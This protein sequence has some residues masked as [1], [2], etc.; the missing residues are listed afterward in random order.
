M[1]RR[2]GTTQNSSRRAVEQRSLRGETLEARRVMATVTGDFN[3]DGID[4][5]AHGLPGEDVGA[6]TDAGAVNVIYG[7]ASYAGLDTP[8]NQIWHQN[9]LGI[10]DVAE[11]H[12]RFGE[13]LAAG[14]FN[15]DGY[16]DLAIAVPGEDIGTNNGAGAVNVIYGSEF[17]LHRSAGAPDQFWHQD[18][19]GIIGAAEPA[20]NF[21]ADLVAADFNG[22]GRDDLAIAVPG[23]DL[24][25]L[26]TVNAGAVN[27]IY[28]RSST[29]GLTSAGDQL[30][31]QDRPGINDVAEKDDR[32]GS[33]L[34]A[35]DFNGDGKA[36]LAIGVSLED[37]GTISNAGAVNVVYGRY[38]YSG[39]NAQGDQFWHQNSV[40]I[41][42]VAE[43]TDRFGSELAA[44]DFN[45]D[46]RD[47]LAV[48]VWGEDLGGITAAG[49]VNVIYGRSS[50]AGLTGAGDQIWH[51]DSSGIHGAAEEFDFFGSA[52]TAAD[53]NGDG[54]DDLAIG[55][56]GESVGNDDRAGAVNVIYGRFG[57]SGLN[58]LNNQI[59]TQDSSGIVGT[60]Q[61]GDQFGAN[62]AAGDFNGDGRS[63]LAVDILCEQIA[64]VP[65]GVPALQV[66]YGRSSTSGLSS[67]GDQLWH[68]GV[69]GIAGQPTAD[70][71]YDPAPIG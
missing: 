29:L 61:T 26:V 38:S 9:Q 22:D 1:L 40:S 20:D 48:G 60:S 2:K 70:D 37:I 21:G 71:K 58:A 36:D 5:V 15:N 13:K 16:V 11:A 33:A 47:D 3:G 32:F 64:E 66:I 31:H 27:V 69:N 8:G 52:L 45:G 55:V 54:K 49:A 56:K 18:S 67:I 14:D 25:T 4:D 30:W 41:E 53:F 50:S 28:G 51:Q 34:T 12:D 17:G 10:A 43:A 68:Q 57:Y 6:I 59:W 24:S 42:G 44:G 35:G 7:N 65:E 46:G 62:L 19:V 23:E 39:L 63:D